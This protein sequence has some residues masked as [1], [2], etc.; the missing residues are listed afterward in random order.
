MKMWNIFDEKTECE[1]E[2]GSVSILEGSYVHWYEV[3]RLIDDYFNNKNTTVEIFEDTQ[4]LHKKDWECFFIPFDIHLQVDKLTSKSPLKTIFDQLS[5]TLSFSPIYIELIQLWEELK[6]E[7]ELLSKKAGKYNLALELRDLN[8]ED[9]KSFLSFKTLKKSMTPIDYKKLLLTL[10][11]ERR[12]EK[13]RLI[14][15][16]LP[17]LYAEESDFLEIMQM[18]Q[19]F[20]EKGILFI[21]ISQRE[22]Q[23][24]VNKL[25]GGKIINNAKLENIKRLVLNDVPFVCE[26]ILFEKTKKNLMKAVNNL[27]NSKENISLSTGYTEDE[28]IVLYVMAQILKININIDISGVSTN[29]MKFAKTYS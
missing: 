11:A 10:Y 14:L 25:I 21:I 9:I 15:I 1:I 8:I 6:D 3:I 4:L 5:E 28:I 17:E 26:E 16:E 22:L 24:N 2:I 13:K 27:K 23:G 12:I 19:F 7:I 29:L 18:I 20:S